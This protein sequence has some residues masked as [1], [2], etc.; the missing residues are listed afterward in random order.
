MALQGALFL[1]ESK[2]RPPRLSEL[3]SWSGAKRVA[4]DIETCD[5]SLFDLGPGVRRGGF[6]AG[7]AFAFEDGPGFYLPIAHEGGDNMEREPVLRYLRDQAANFTHTIVGTN[8]TYDL[9]YLAEAGVT[10]D[11]AAWFRDV[12]VAEPLIDEL[13]DTY[14]LDA[15]AKRYK[16]RGKEYPL[17]KDALDAYGLKGR[18]GQ[19]IWKLPARFVGEYATQDVFLPLE[20]LR[21]QEREIEAQD[22][23]AVYDLESQLLPVLLKMRR[24]GVRFSHERL[25]RVERWSEIEEQKALDIIAE[26]TSYRIGLGEVWA[27][28]PFAKA[29]KEIGVVAPLVAKGNKPSITA[30]FLESI[31]HPAAKAMVRARQ[32]N[33]LRSTFVNSVRN[34]A[35]GDRIHCVTNQLRKEKEDGGLGGAAYGRCSSEHPNMQQQPARDPEMGP[36]WRSI[37]IPDEGGLWACLDYS[38]QEPRLLTHYAEL[39]RC[40]GAAAAAQRYRDDPKTDNH[41][42]MAELTGLPRKQAK[43]IFLGK[44]YGMGGAKLCHEVGLPT[45]WKFS[46]KLGRTIEVA[47][48]EGAAILEQFDRR[49]PYVKQ[50]AKKC[51]ERAKANGYIITIGGRRCRFPRGDNGEFDWTHKALNRL[52]QGGSGDQTKAAMVAGDRAGYPL[53]L[54]V[55]DELDLTV[56]N[57]EQAEGLAEIMRNVLPLRVPSRVD[58]EIG[59]SWG[60]CK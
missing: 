26:Q 44:C 16:L 39:S 46:A 45:E 51:E 31:D 37:Y 59:P 13:Q 1:P 53:Q 19:H 60:E 22:L 42:M 32:V 30:E 48:P 34:Y 8:L 9:D 17:M 57:R 23:W 2:W 33:K 7:V 4:V 28:E 58:V 49:A 12:Q 10:F 11:R 29:L 14:N 6:I 25:E 35:I 36:L 54:Q 43:N 38:Q 20:L 56:A 3:P 50:L 18:P 52:I 5:P 24:R 41:A 21:R 40:K 15:I 55:H 27:P 47:G